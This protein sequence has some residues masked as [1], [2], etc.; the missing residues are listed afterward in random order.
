MRALDQAGNIGDDKAAVVFEIHDT[1]VRSQCGE[2]VIGDFWAGCADARNESR[3]ACVWKTNDR[4]VCEEFE[5]EFDF[6]C[7]A[8]LARLSELW[9]LESGAHE[10]SVALPAAAAFASDP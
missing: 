7:G 1:E 9:S 4:S 10:M 2:S 6:A 8:V 3:L 5:L